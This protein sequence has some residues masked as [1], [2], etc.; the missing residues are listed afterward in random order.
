M[1]PIS[2]VL[3]SACNAMLSGTYGTVGAHAQLWPQIYDH[4]LHQGPQHWQATIHQFALPA[5]DVCA[6]LLYVVVVCLRVIHFVTHLTDT[7]LLT[8]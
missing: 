7:T 4:H 6:I 3:S 2:V 8:Q 1:L 5:L